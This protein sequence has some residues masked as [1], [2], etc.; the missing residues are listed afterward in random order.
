MDGV[1]DDTL[2]GFWVRTVFAN[3]NF[4]IAGNGDLW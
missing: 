4:P 2:V 3:T 1:G